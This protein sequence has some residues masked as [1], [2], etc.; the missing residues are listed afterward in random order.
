MRGS[1]GV[2]RVGKYELGRTLGEGNFAKVKLGQDVESGRRVAIKVMDKD[3]ILQHRMAD[4]IKREVSIMKMVRHPNIVQLIEVLASRNK[5]F[6]VLEFAAGGELFDRIV[7]RGRL[8]ESEARRYFQQL[9]DAVDCCH[10]KGVCHRDLKPENLLVDERGNLKVSDFGLSALPQQQHR[11]GLLH[12]TCGT[13]NYVAPEVLHNKGYD[14]RK[15]DVWSCGVILFVLLAGYVPF[16]EPDLVLLYDKV[17]CSMTRCAAAMNSLHSCACMLSHVLHAASPFL[18]LPCL[19]TQQSSPLSL[20]PH[21]LPL[22]CSPPPDAIPPPP[23]IPR[24][25]QVPRVVLPRGEAPHHAHPQPR[26]RH[27]MYAAPLDPATVYMPPF[28]TPPLYAARPPRPPLLVFL[29]VPLFPLPGPHPCV[30]TACHAPPH[31]LSFLRTPSCSHQPFFRPSLS[32][33]PLAPPP[34][35]STL[36]SF[37]PPS[38]ARRAAVVWQRPGLEAIRR[39]EWFQRDYQRA[40]PLP[41]DTEGQG[42]TEDVLL[43]ARVRGEGGKGGGSGRGRGGRGKGRDGEGQREGGMVVVDVLIGCFA[44]CCAMPSP[45]PH[46]SCL[47]LKPPSIPI[48]ALAEL[49]VRVAHSPSLQ[50]SLPVSLSPRTTA[51]AAPLA[52]LGGRE[53]QAGVA[54]EGRAGGAGEGGPGAGAGEEGPELVNAFDLIARAHALDLGALFHRR[55]HPIRLERPATAQGGHL[56]VVIQIFEMTAGVFMVEARK[57]AGDTLEYHK[58]ATAVALTALLSTKLTDNLSVCGK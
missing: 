1:S 9:V 25:L 44:L 7:Y 32:H 14:G 49:S 6:M 50:A 21:P 27:R 51:A 55:A 20:C 42:G 26:P 41:D 16:D 58:W 53:A 40:Y 48:P 37:P 22:S 47:L 31:R 56:T 10:A 46:S 18:Q 29:S 33:S 36:S 3:R 54:E 23:D 4:Q 45:C 43:H 38:R 52:A 8:S 35:F 24:A 11:D 19:S 39:D 13:P 30:L 2:K 17:C 12:T 34:P 5:I 15:A 28:F 57:A